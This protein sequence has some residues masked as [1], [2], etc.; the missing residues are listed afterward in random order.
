MPED[1]PSIPLPRMDKK[2]IKWALFWALILFGP[3]LVRADTPIT[4]AASWQDWT[5]TSLAGIT[6]TNGSGSFDSSVV[7]DGD[8]SLKFIYGTNSSIT[9]PYRYA[10]VN[11]AYGAHFFAAI[12]DRNTSTNETYLIQFLTN[13][14]VATMFT[15]HPGRTFWNRCEVVQARGYRSFRP[16][17]PADLG[18]A[19]NNPYI[20]DNPTSIRIVPPPGRPGTVYLGKLFLGS[21][22][23][24]TQLGLQPDMVSSPIAAS[25]PTPPVTVTAGQSNDIAQI[26]ARLEEVF[27]VAPYTAVSALSSY[28][29]L[30]LRTNYLAYLIQS[31]AVAGIWSGTNS[32]MS[33][34]YADYMSNEGALGDLMLQI[35][36]AF[37][38]TLDLAQQQELRTNYLNLFDFAECIGGIPDNWA[39]GQSYLPSIF[40]MRQEL[41]NR[42]TPLLLNTYQERIGFNRIYLGRSWLAL[43]GITGWSPDQSSRD[44]NRV[45]ETGEDVDFMRI[46]S[47]QL[48]MHAV[49]RGSP[50]ECVRDLQAV[51]DYFSNIAFAYSPGMLDGFRP[52]GLAFHH[53][54]WIYGYGLDCLVQTP[55]ILYALA[56]TGFRIQPDAHQR[57]RDALISLDWMSMDSIVPATLSGKGGFPYAY[58]G[59]QHN[60]ADPYACL[61]LSGT[62]DGT[63]P[64]DPNMAALFQRS[65]ADY[66]PNAHTAPPSAFV[67]QQHTNLL[68]YAPSALPE[69]S[70]IFS[71]GNMVA[72]HKNNWLLTLRGHSKYQYTR[73]STDPWVTYLGYGML[74]LVTTNYWLRNGISKLVTGFGTGG[75][76]WR[77]YPGTTTVNYANITNLINHE[78]DRDY[79]NPSF[80]GGVTQNHNALFILR[81]EGS[82]TNGL[83]TYRADK[84]WF[85]FDDTVV[86]LGTGIRNG[87]SGDPTVTTLY[88]ITNDLMTPTYYNSLTGNT[89][90]IS[91]TTTNLAAPAWLLDNQGTGYWVP[92]NSSLSVQHRSQTNPDWYNTNNTSGNYAVAWINHGNAPTNASYCYLQIPQTTPAAMAALSTNM[93]GPTPNFR[94][95]AQ[96]T[97]IHAVWSEP[98]QTYGVMVLDASAPVA[99]R[100]VLSVSRPCTLLMQV[101]GTAQRKL[102]LADPDLDE[103]DN[104]VY[105]NNE[106]WGYSQP[107]THTLNLNGVWYLAQPATNVVAI[108]NNVA[109]ATTTLSVVLKDGLTTDVFL[110]GAPPAPAALTA[111]AVSGARIDLAWSP[112]TNATSYTIKRGTLSGGPY[113]TLATGVASTQWS[114]VTAAPGTLYFYVVAATRAGLDGANSVEASAALTLILDNAGASGVA[115]SGAWTVGTAGAGWYGADYLTDGTPHTNGKSVTFTPVFT[116]PGSN[117]VYLRWVAGPD[118]ATNVPVEVNSA[119]GK[120]TLL[121]NQQ[122]NGGTWVLLGT[123][124]FDAGTGGSVVIRNDG[125]NGL[126]IADA[127][128][129]VPVS[130]G[131]QALAPTI[132]PGPLTDYLNGLSVTLVGPSPGTT[133]RYTLDGSAPSDTNGSVYTGPIF[134]D[135]HGAMIQAVAYGGGYS[136]S[137]VTLAQYDAHTALEVSPTNLNVIASAGTT[138][139]RS[140]TLFNHSSSNQTVSLAVSYSGSSLMGSYLVSTNANGATWSSIAGTGARVWTGF[141]DDDTSPALNMGFALPFHGFTTSNLW[142]NVN[143][144]AAFSNTTSTAYNNYPLTNN[145]VDASVPK[146]A[147]F[148]FWDDQTLAGNLTSSNLFYQ[149]RTGPAGP[150]FVVEWNNVVLYGKT[151]PHTYQLIVRPNGEMLFLYQAIPATDNSYTVGMV[152]SGNGDGIQ[153][154]NDTISALAGT[155]T[156]LRFSPP[157]AALPATSVTI[158]ANSSSTVAVTFL[159]SNLGNGNSGTASLVITPLT[160]GI[161]GP[162]PVSLTLSAVNP[163][164]L[165]VSSDH[166]TPSP[167]GMTT[168]P[169]GTGMNAFIASPVVNGTTQY[170]ATG[171]SGTGSVGG[172]IGTNV[173]ITLTNNTTLTWLWQTNL[174]VNLNTLGN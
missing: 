26:T 110:T 33:V 23:Q 121:V 131:L 57:L 70:R 63:L 123:F 89:A 135:Y 165:T 46:I 28:D 43:K 75:Y 22:G 24:W 35:A 21:P 90:P 47:I 88:Q 144:W 167:V 9:F 32:M 61:A 174:W 106:S 71:Y 116:V 69:G 149:Q 6:M 53:W 163:P 140:L 120:T 94:V 173:S 168:S 95:L 1:A 130:S 83:G 55:Q 12:F 158:P 109:L 161:S 100:D 79:G 77:L 148:P 20:P 37:R 156:A 25:P 147:V 128:E 19:T 96:T 31:N 108:S 49:L 86:A 124:P 166:G 102:S 119:L 104:T 27:G 111:T 78:S 155:N 112:S 44:T 51:S 160:A 132:A 172:G 62:P 143:G 137:P 5:A 65:Y 101:T 38:N 39:A 52:D 30:K 59:N 127:V 154:V 45:G 10:G 81:L 134:V 164:T 40:L 117:Q 72:H 125:A 85:F 8:S 126:V 115:I 105:Q 64:I 162:P 138:N 73:Q 170:V 136:V 153:L 2:C 58:G 157:W 36:T 48:V 4:S 82:V 50:A 84:S 151:V 93:N 150:E 114:D 122:I 139:T 92:T 60:T 146:W 99:I 91:D 34:G 118:R 141:H 103:I 87:L 76:D 171:W 159:P 17:D 29:F 98:Q 66:L 41:T 152:G 74:D 67:S 142:A 3:A 145:P 42:L 7:F 68:A 97:K 107:H 169:Y 56:G 54:N 11:L 133:V 113:T 15:W 80:V 129:F 14:S 18:Y 13:G 16:E